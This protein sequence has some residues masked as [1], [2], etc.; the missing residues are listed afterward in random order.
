VIDASVATIDFSLKIPDRTA[1]IMVAA[2]N[3][4]HDDSDFSAH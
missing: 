1:T 4:G 3:Q 2:S